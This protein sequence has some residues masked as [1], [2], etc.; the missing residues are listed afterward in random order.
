MNYAVDMSVPSSLAFVSARPAHLGW[1]VLALV[2]DALP[3]IALWMLISLLIY[4]IHGLRPVASD[5][6]GG[7][8]ELV[9]LW[10]MTGL[11]AVESWA[12]GGQTIGMRPW[13]LK[14]L[15]ADG[16]VATRRRLWLRYAVASLSLAAVGLG[17]AWSLIERERRTWHD[18]AS[19]TTLL[20]LNKR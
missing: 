17:F 18:L 13:R 7:W 9:A 4:L 12:R 20:R 16:A 11:Y 10:A 3:V 19:G 8:I 5:S 14:L 15:R 1:R 6:L 2:Y